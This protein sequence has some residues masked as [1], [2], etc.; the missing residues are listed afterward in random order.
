MS[1]VGIRVYEH[2]LQYVTWGYE[3]LFIWFQFLCVSREDMYFCIDTSPTT[4]L[5]EKLT[6]STEDLW[7]DI[8]DNR[9]Y[10]LFRLDF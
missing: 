10:L 6:Y 4:D 7:Y 9:K 2:I 1:I 3:N 5:D 8:F